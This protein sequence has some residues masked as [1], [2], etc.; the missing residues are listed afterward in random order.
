MSNFLPVCR[1]ITIIE[2]KVT[3]FNAEC[4]KFYECYYDKWINRYTLHVFPC[5]VVLGYDTDIT[6]C[7][8]PFA[9]PSTQCSSAGIKGRRKRRLK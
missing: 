6:A 9:G 1:I 4:D 3:A 7:N 5:P 8:Y 2:L